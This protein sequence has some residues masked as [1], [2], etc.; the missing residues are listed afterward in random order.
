VGLAFDKSGNLYVA[1]N[2]AYTV[3]EFDSNGNGHVFADLRSQ[4]YYPNFLA[5]DSTGN[6]YV[7]GRGGVLEYDPYG[8]MFVFAVAGSG[9]DFMSVAV[10]PIP[11]PSMVT[12][13]LLGAGAF[14]VAFR[15][16]IGG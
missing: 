16:R 13:M 7:V 4:P 6:L 12:L 15:S 1:N 14:L 10:Q 3:T 5:F 8:N 2:V 9:S 11:E